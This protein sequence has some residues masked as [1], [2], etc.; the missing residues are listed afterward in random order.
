MPTLRCILGH[1]HSGG[2]FL[3]GE[4][5]GLVTY[6]VCMITCCYTKVRAEIVERRPRSRGAVDSGGPM[7]DAEVYLHVMPRR[8]RGVWVAYQ[9]TEGSPGADL[10]QGVASYHEAR[11]RAARDGYRLCFDEETWA[12]MIEA[13]V[14]PQTVP[15]DVTLV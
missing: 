14:A 13:G 11:D 8:R 6:R 2:Y 15:D 1:L 3:T 4:S 9:I 10:V 12:Q 7:T 5:L